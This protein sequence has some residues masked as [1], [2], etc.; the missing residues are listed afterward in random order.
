VRFLEGILKRLS[1]LAALREGRPDAGGHSVAQSLLGSFLARG[2]HILTYLST[3]RARLI[4]PSG[5]LPGREKRLAT[6]VVG[7][8]W[9]FRS[10][11]RAFEHHGRLFHERFGL[12]LA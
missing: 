2:P 8:R 5:A 12:S 6:L 10:S 11:V 3:V 9:G 7:L 1:L 4:E